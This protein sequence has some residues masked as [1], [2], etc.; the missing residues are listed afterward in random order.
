MW[1]TDE[2]VESLPQIASYSAYYDV[3]SACAV[4]TYVQYKQ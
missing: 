1:F 2:E 3:S 4:G